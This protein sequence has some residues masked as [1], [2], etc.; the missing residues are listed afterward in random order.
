MIAKSLD[1]K[2]PPKFKNP[3]P[4]GQN[5]H[6]PQLVSGRGGVGTMRCDFFVIKD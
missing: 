2:T 1:M 6:P 4:D 3:F 5:L